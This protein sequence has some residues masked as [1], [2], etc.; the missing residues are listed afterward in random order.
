VMALR[1]RVRV[2]DFMAWFSSCDRD[3]FREWAV[4]CRNFSPPPSALDLTKSGCPSPAQ[5]SE[6][7]LRFPSWKGDVAT[8]AAADHGNDKEN[9]REHREQPADLGGHS[10]D[11]LEPEHR[12]NQSDDEKRYCI[13]QHGVT[14]FGP[15]RFMRIRA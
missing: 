10:G 14:P 2:L 13:T 6:F 1:L 15:A 8:T 12:C 11:T 4:A 5:V 9:Q 7:C 3:F